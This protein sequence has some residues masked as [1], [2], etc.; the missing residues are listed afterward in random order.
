M[1]KPNVSE[2]LKSFLLKNEN[3]KSYRIILDDEHLTKGSASMEWFNYW[4]ELINMNEMTCAFA[5]EKE[6]NFNVT[7]DGNVYIMEIVRVENIANIIR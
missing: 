5:D 3:D 4:D 2:Q 1:N 7:I 6:N